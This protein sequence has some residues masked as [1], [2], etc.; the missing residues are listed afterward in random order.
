VSWVISYG[1]GFVEERPNLKEFIISL[2]SEP[3]QITLFL[4]AKDKLA[5]LVKQGKVSL[6][7]RGK[8]LEDIQSSLRDARDKILSII[9]SSKLTETQRFK[10]M[11]VARYLEKFQRTPEADNLKIIHRMRKGILTP[12]VFLAKDHADEWDVD[13]ADEEQVEERD[14]YSK[15]EVRECIVREV[16]RAAS[17]PAKPKRHACYKHVACGSSFTLGRSVSNT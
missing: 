8:K 4:G 14:I 3:N 17:S 10:G 1:A 11:T 7:T 5:E 15:S 16:P 12:C 13:V 9:R 2:R 6:K